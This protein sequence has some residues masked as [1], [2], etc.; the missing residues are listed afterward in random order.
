[1]AAGSGFAIAVGTGIL[2]KAKKFSLSGYSP[3]PA[4]VKLKRRTQHA[5]ARR[6]ARFTP[7]R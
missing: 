2:R 7:G 4:C 5:A 6:N 1:M 3:A